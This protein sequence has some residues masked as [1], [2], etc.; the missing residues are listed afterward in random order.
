[1]KGASIPACLAPI[2]DAVAASRREQDRFRAVQAR[3][4]A[5]AAEVR[6][7]LPSAVIEDGGEALY[8]GAL[9][10]GCRACKN[11]AWDCIFVTM[12][13]NLDCAFCWRPNAPASGHVGSV[14]GATREA[15]AEPYA[16]A[17]VHGISL[18][19]GEPFLEWESL[20]DWLVWLTSRYPDRYYWVYTNGLLVREE[21]IHRL[22][23]IG[24]NELR[25]NMAAGGY[26]HAAA[27]SSLAAAAR[28]LPA[29]TVEIPA[30]PEDRERVL[31]A[32]HGWCEAG[33]KYLN[34]HELVYEPG[35]NS[36]LMPG[37]R[38]PGRLGDGHAFDFNPDS[39]AL[40]LEVMERVH[41]ER[42][43]L[44]VNDCSLHSKFRQLRGRRRMLAPVTKAAHEKLT[45]EGLL[46]S[47]CMDRGTDCIVF[48]PE[49]LNEMRARY[50][51]RRFFRLART[52]PLSRGQPGRWR[53]FEPL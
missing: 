29:A 3:W 23:E 50:P 14:F 34:L 38:E 19:G 44:A 43:P 13:C 39:R 36:G 11:G 49:Q 52:V 5:H 1:M 31:S 15:V 32:L 37:A 45:E 47:C 27:M 30:I 17:A 53:R 51:D 7:R 9:S 24:L 4:T 46:E 2:K 18:S 40:V 8:L 22:S 41:A 25:F 21:Q 12:E 16:H 10:P 26:T 6:R 33:V 35:T 42:L 20:A 48:H 28:L